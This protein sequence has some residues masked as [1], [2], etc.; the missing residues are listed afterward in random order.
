MR[1][2]KI[3]EAEFEVMKVIWE[4]APVSSQEIIESLKDRC[5]W[6]PQTIKTLITRLMK[7]K[8]VGYSK[9]G[10]SYM[11]SPLLDKDECLLSESDS[12]LKRL[13]GGTLEPM[14]LHFAKGK[15]LSQKDVEDL[16]RILNKIKE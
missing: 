3:S 5:D 16:K 8:A 2:P 12:F 14:L 4:K 7:K 6:A 10:K 11:Y 9:N 1:T 13:F 15:N